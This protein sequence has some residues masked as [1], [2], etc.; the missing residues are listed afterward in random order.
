MSACVKIVT[1]AIKNI[2]MAKAELRIKI[3]MV[4]QNIVGLKP[5]SS[6]IT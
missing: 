5:M 2:F 1:N 4:S 6:T 3:N